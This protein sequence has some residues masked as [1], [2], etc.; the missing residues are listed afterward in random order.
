MQLQVETINTCHP[1]R[2]TGVHLK[3]IPSNLRQCI[4]VHMHMIKPADVLTLVQAQ[5][6]TLRCPVWM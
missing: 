4:H 5:S 2:S 1:A 3:Q 6:L